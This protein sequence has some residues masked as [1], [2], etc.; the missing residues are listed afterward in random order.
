[1][2]FAAG[3]GNGEQC[4]KGSVYG[5]AWVK[6]PI[7]DYWIGGKVLLRSSNHQLPDLV[8]A[9]QGPASQPIALEL[10]SKTDSVKGA[11]RN[12]FE[13]VPDQP[14]EQARVVL[15]GGNKRGLVVNSRNLCKQS[16]RA[17]R[18]NVRMVAQ[19]GKAAQLRPLVRNSCRKAHKKRHK[20]HHKRRR[21]GNHSRGARR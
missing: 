18:A 19:S 9:L 16:K 10:S 20:S 1:M 13:A 8:I 11:L 14:F 4:P 7:L 3:A 21:K 5:H 17:S 15:F 2:Q 6:T 12:T